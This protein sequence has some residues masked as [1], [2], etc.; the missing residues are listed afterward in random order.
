MTARLL[1]FAAAESRHKDR[2]HLE[3]VYRQ[4]A[5]VTAERDRARSLAV[6]LEAENHRLT[7]ERDR[8]AQ[9]LRGRI[10]ESHAV[11]QFAQ[12]V[13]TAADRAMPGGEG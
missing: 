7:I 5:D 1:R 6:A 9:E 8:L 2:T 10:V 4:L 13:R 11:S 3:A 12:Y